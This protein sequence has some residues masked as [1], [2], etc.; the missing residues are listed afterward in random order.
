[1]SNSASMTKEQCRDWFCEI[2]SAIEGGRTE[3]DAATDAATGFEATDA[4]VEADGGL[5]AGG[6]DA[7]MA[8]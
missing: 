8:Y 5:E 2:D 7:A 1:M 6:E 3:L 4:A